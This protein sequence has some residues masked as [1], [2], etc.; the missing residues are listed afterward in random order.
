MSTNKPIWSWDLCNL[1]NE[2][3]NHQLTSI[4]LTPFCKFAKTMQIK[5]TAGVTQQGHW[6]SLSCSDSPNM[7]PHPCQIQMHFFWRARQ[8]LTFMKSLTNIGFSNVNSIVP[9]FS[10][11]TYKQ[12]HI[13]DLSFMGSKFKFLELNTH[14]IFKDMGSYPL[15]IAILVD[16]HI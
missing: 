10:R 16:I 11:F 7:L 4:I 1:Q 9:A 5:Y 13:Q 14:Y 3:G 12:G 2:V 15:F 6:F 8:A